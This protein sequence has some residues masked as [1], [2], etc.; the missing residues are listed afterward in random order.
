MWSR[1]AW[2]V[3]ARRFGVA[4]V[5]LSVAAV[6]GVAAGDQY[7]RREYAKRSTVHLNDGVLAPQLAAQPAN[8]LLIGHDAFGNSDTMMVVHVDPAV[9]TPLVVSFPRDLMLNVPGHGIGQ[10][11]STFGLGGPA[12]LIQT[13]QA[14]FAIPIQHYLQVDFATFPQIVDAIGHVNVWF[15]TAVHDPYLGL[16]IDRPGCVSLN[17]QTALAYVRSRHYYVP[18]NLAAPAPWV[19]DYPAQ[20]G[21]QGWTAIGSDIERVPRQQYF[22]RTL[23][24]TALTKTNDDPLKIVGVVDAVMTHLTTDQSLTLSEL[25]AL[26]ATFRRARPR[27]IEMTTI[28]WQSDATNANRVVVK[29][30]EAVPLLNRL[31]NFTRP[32][33]K[34][35]IMVDPHTVRVRV[36]NGS[37]VPGLATKVLER[38]T[39]AGFRS[40]GPAADADRTYAHTQVRFAPGKNAEGLT[41][42]YATGAH[43]V[44][45]SPA[46]ADTLGGDVLVI[47]GRDWNTLHPLLNGL[48][49]T[50]PTSPPHNVTPTTQVSGASPPSTLDPRYIPLDP[51]TGGVLVGCP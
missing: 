1:P 23:A 21:G 15:P 37:G 48:P 12:L 31:A 11:N 29:Y 41:V 38:L 51:K 50:Q 2:L 9:R 4:L 13:L 34:L 7:G 24:Q 36:V 5:I 17:G 20:S 46:A 30:P 43:D 26:V 27:D 6:G 49:K 42:T 32:T 33:P 39:A 18:D 35:P 47:V 3:F 28:P 10:L 8:F 19:W 40:A 22:L 45:Q 14:D 16:N 25:K 44:G